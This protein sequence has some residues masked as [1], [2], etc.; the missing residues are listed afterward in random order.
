MGKIFNQ[1]RDWMFSDPF[2][3]FIGYTVYI[4]TI[5]IFF[6]VKPELLSKNI[7]QN[8]FF[9]Y[10]GSVLVLIAWIIDKKNYS[11]K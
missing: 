3:G 1:F 11:S 6:I 5:M 8:I 7:L 10:L 4:S 9:F 2:K